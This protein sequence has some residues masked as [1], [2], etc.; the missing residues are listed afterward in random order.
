MKAIVTR[1][2]AQAKPL[3][4]ALERAGVEVVECPLIEIERT[5]DEP[6]DAAGY[7]WLIV[8]SP[9]GADE[10]ARRGRNLPQVAAVGPGTAETLRAHGIEPAFVPRRVVAGRAAARVPAT[11][12]PGAL[13]GGGG[14]ARAARSRS[15]APTSSRSTARGCSSRSRPA[16]DVVVLASGSAARAYAGI[17]GAAPAVTIGPETTRVAR[18]GRARGRGRGGDARSRRPRRRGARCDG[19]ACT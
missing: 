17:G 2:R 5:S 1:P 8:T 12:R 16:G 6:I 14:R 18:V 13:R 4:G 19:L 15:S 7:D 3:V 10:I 11:R 9:N